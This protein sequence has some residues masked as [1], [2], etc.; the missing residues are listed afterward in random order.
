MRLP[1]LWLGFPAL[2]LEV[3]SGIVEYQS[4]NFSPKA[5]KAI[6]SVDFENFYIS[7]GATTVIGDTPGMVL[8]SLL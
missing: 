4:F 8:G 5:C 7:F 6:I 3:F 2:Y 1:E